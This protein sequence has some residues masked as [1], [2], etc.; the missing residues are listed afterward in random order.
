MADPLESTRQ[1]VKEKA[2]QEFH[3]IQCQGAL[4]MAPLVIL[5]AEGHCAI[6]AGEEPSIAD[7]HPMCIAGE[8]LENLLRAGQRRFGV[9]DPLRLPQGRDKLAPGRWGRQALTL[10]MKA[11]GAL[12]H[13]VTEGREKGATEAATEHLDREEEVAGA[14]QP[15]RAIP[16]EAASGD[17]AVHMRMMTTTLTIP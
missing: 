17:E 1:D 13:G 5:P 9:D 8:V 16:S 2:A 12:R 15:G 3:R 4:P 6:R 7:C 11:Y 10:P 14:R